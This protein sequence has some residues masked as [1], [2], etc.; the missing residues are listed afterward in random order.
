[1]GSYVP[2]KEMSDNDVY[3]IN[4]EFFFSGYMVVNNKEIR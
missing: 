4:P 3:E 2:V 1:M